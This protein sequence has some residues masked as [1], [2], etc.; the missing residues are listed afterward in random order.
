MAG[1]KIQAAE[2]P[3]GDIFSDEYRFSIPRYQRPYAWT[4]EQAGELL[5]DLLWAA[6][7]KPSLDDADPYFLGSVVLVKAE[8]DAHAEVVDGQQRLTT[9][10]ILLS[11]LRAHVSAE[12]AASLDA[13]VFQRGDPIRRTVDQPRLRRRRPVA[14]GIQ[15]SQTSS[16]N[17]GS[18]GSRIW[19]SSLA[20]RTRRPG[21][22]SSMPR[23][24]STSQRRPASRPSS[25]PL[26]C[27][28]N[29]SGHQHSSSSG[30]RLLSRS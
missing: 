26:R 29:G 19:C 18:T 16:A 30:K 27:S 5:D 13:R 24:H 14:P 21:T 15:A 23:R 11:A 20:G 12:F 2:R 4:P 1:T 8:S 17:T 3:I 7:T 9:L 22:T 25:S 6:F 10:T 28:A